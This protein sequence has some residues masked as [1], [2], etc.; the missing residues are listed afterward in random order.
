MEGY[1]NDKQD[2]AIKGV[3]KIC[4]IGL[5]IVLVKYSKPL[6]ITVSVILFLF[7][8]DNYFNEGKI[9]EKLLI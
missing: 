3:F 5:S 4:L 6:G 2:D 9:E 7:L 8:I 1:V